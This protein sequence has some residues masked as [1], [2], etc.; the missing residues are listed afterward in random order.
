[1]SCES[2]RI[3]FVEFIIF[4]RPDLEAQ[5][6]NGLSALHVAAEQGRQ[7]IVNLLLDAGAG[8]NEKDNGGLNV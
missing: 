6:N 2:G 1:M 3:D 5:N 8:Q 7:D 4:L